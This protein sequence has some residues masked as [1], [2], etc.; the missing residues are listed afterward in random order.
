MDA[1]DEIAATQLHL[2]DIEVWLQA[3]KGKGKESDIIDIDEAVKD[4]AIQLNAHLMALQDQIMCVSIGTAVYE[5]GVELCLVQGAENQALLDKLQARLL[6]EPEAAAQ[7]AV[8]D[9]SSSLDAL[10]DETIE[11][12][13][14]LNIVPP[15]FCECVK[16]SH[17]D[18]EQCAA[19][20][21]HVSRNEIIIVPCDHVYCVSCLAQLF[22]EALRDESLFP[23]RCCRNSIPSTQV[24]HV[25]GA[26]MINRIQ[27]KAIE[28]AT[29]DRTYC[30]D[31]GCATFIPPSLVC[32]AK[33]TCPQCHTH[34]C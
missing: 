14:Q 20:M 13:T 2:E 30:S 25:V 29:A 26:K 8:I 27:F 7:T 17:E 12:L 16:P 28:V 22:E 1:A 32:G 4:Q 19:C 15:S 18:T 31:P 24:A 11:R 23:P 10:D 21:I 34:T 3:R 5:D 6:E 9:V 33:A